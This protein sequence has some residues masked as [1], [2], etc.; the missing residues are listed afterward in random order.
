MK[1]RPILF[2]G[3]MVKAILDGRKTQTRRVI[4]NVDGRNWLK[5]PKGH[6]GTHVIDGVKYC[7]YGQVGDQLW[8][9]EKFSYHRIPSGEPYFYPE[10]RLRECV[11][12]DYG[13][14]YW[15]DGDPEYGDW[16]RPKPSIHMPRIAS[17]ISLEIT[18]VRV[19]LLNETTGLDAIAEGIERVE[20]EAPWRTFKR[21]WDSINGDKHPW[22]SNPWV[23]VVEF[24]IATTSEGEG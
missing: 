4:K 13:F 24:K 2:S 7:P 1:E 22:E 12:A 17:R 18:N 3:E 10:D 9:R 15:A 14:H 23:W 16:T 19:E 21:L 20:S 5:T 11:N 6:A 8:V